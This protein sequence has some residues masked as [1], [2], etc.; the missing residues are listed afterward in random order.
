M[1]QNLNPACRHAKKRKY[2]SYKK[3]ILL[4]HTNKYFKT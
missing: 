2:N 4:Q 1:L 3:L